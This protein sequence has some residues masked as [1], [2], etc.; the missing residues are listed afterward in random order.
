MDTSNP[1]RPRGSDPKG[2]NGPSGSKGIALKAKGR[3]AVSQAFWVSLESRDDAPPFTQIKGGEKVLTPLGAAVYAAWRSLG[4]GRPSLVTDAFAIGP[5]SFQGILRIK[6]A[7]DAPA[8]PTALRLFKT[9]SARSASPVDRDE[10]A[11]R[12]P[13]S[14]LWKKGYAEKALSTLKQVVDAR[15]AL[16]KA[17]TPRA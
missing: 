15:A 4:D 9:L 6:D 12:S 5:H 17:H 10:D 13:A 7:P 16:K 8:L 11:A 3:A 2:A 14:A 1:S